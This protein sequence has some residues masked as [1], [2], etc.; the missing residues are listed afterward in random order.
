MAH[1]ILLMR[2]PHAQCIVDATAGNGKDT[3]FLAKHAVSDA[4]V[5]AFDIQEQAIVKTKQLLLDNQYQNKVKCILDSHC[6]I[7][8]YIKEKVD[9]VTFN[10]G[11][12]PGSSHTITTSVETT[13]Q[14]INKSIQLLNGNGIITI[15]AYPGH[16]PGKEESS[17]LLAQLSKLPQADFNVGCWQMLNQVN[18]PPVLYLV[19]KKRGEVREGFASRED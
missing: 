13:I 10:L 11:Y 1:Q 4:R 5:W 6:N 18:E 12:L 3:L 17:A 8:H 2:L 7:D 15:V 14:A 19:E 9:I 16:M